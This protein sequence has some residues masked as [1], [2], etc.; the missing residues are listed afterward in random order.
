[1][2]E[3]TYKRILDLGK[4]IEKQYNSNA[5]D[6]KII[7]DGQMLEALSKKAL[8]PTDLEKKLKEI[9]NKRDEL[10]KQDILLTKD[11]KELKRQEHLKFVKTGKDITAE[12][13]EFI[14][15]LS[16]NH[17][18]LA[19]TLNFNPT[20]MTG[21][22]NLQI[23]NN[24]VNEWWKLLCSYILGRDASKYK[25]MTYIGIV[26][27]IYSNIHGHLAVK[28]PNIITDEFIYDIEMVIQVLWK[29]VQIG[30]SVYVDRIYSNGWFYYMTKDSNFMKH[31][32]YSPK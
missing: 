2:L 1:M 30:G 24:K 16:D 22:F 32:I 6:F 28:I 25:S 17:F 10:K 20:N 21:D 7:W 19:V 14:K 26:E 23:V 29:T 8:I 4:V 11:Y 15:M 12:R 27:H 18:N 9:E 13:M 5:D 31:L 3:D